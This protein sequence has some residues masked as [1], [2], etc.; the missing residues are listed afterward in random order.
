MTMNTSAASAKDTI[1]ER[2]APALEAFEANV[3]QARRTFTARRH[4]AEDFGAEAA[5][6]VRRHPLSA[7]AL[8]AAVGLVG[9]CLIGLAFGWQ[10]GSRRSA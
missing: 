1:T 8:A 3:R 5:L 7:V 2:M 9:G 10:V 6:Q 4:A